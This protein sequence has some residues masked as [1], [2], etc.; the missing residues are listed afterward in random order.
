MTPQNSERAIPARG[1]GDRSRGKC[2]RPLTFVS[3][4]PRSYDEEHLELALE[5]G[6]R[7]ALAIEWLPASMSAERRARLDSYD[8]LTHFS[9]VLIL[10]KPA[11]S[12]ATE[13]FV[14]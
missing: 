3:S 6:R 7:V 10:Q 12:C 1:A 9:A 5:I 14:T 4:Q 13:N 11:D 2:L 8:T